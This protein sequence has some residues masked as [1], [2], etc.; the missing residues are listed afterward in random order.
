[1]WTASTSKQSNRFQTRLTTI[2]EEDRGLTWCLQPILICL[3][4]FGID[5]SWKEQRST[6]RHYLIRFGS[7]FW[8][9][10]NVSIT[11]Y[12]AVD[13][14]NKKDNSH[15]QLKKYFDHLSK[16]S[17]YLQTSVLYVAFLFTTWRHGQD[18]VKIF[19][20]METDFQIGKN[21]YVKARQVVI[22]AIA[23]SLI[24]VKYIFI[25]FLK[26]Y[27]NYNCGSSNRFYLQEIVASISYGSTNFGS[28]GI[29][30][31]ACEVIQWIMDIN[32][33]MSVIMFCVFSYSVALQYGEIQTQIEN[34]HQPGPDM[35]DQMRSWSVCH[36]STSSVVTKM[37]EFFSPLLLIN[38]A[39]TYVDMSTSFAATIIYGQDFSEYAIDCIQLFVLFYA[40]CSAADYM[41]DSVMQSI[42]KKKKVS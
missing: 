5:L 2:Y 21:S 6:F 20:Q 40:T 28:S 36:S 24:T 34:I 29:I 16:I 22:V 39:A 15:R 42:C 33:S 3:R 4:L 17:G 14:Y 23:L 12:L 1:M 27:V 7:L 19:Q 31:S 11:S 37:N 41:R 13:Q 9:I 25:L 38:T 10:V 18:L 26:K 35:K 8:L 30:F 32:S